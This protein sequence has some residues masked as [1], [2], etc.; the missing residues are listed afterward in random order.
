MTSKQWETLSISK[1]IDQG[2]IIIG[3]G[4]RTKNSE[5]STEG[6]PFARVANINDGFHF[7]GADYFPVEDLYKVGNKISRVNDIVFTSKGTVG[8]FA[9]VKQ[10]TSQFVYSP[11]LCF[12]R[13]LDEEI[14]LPRFLYYWMQSSEFE[15]QANSVKGQTDMA[16]YVSLYDQR[17]MKITLPPPHPTPHCRQPFCTGRQDRTEPPDQRHAGSHCPSYLGSSQ[18][19]GN[20]SV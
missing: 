1:L 15:A 11:Q 18:I 3:D 5:L 19:S 13:V 4:Y 2:V 8:R 17:R 20:G 12:W 14:I 10:D 9:F 7:E 6:I 16:D